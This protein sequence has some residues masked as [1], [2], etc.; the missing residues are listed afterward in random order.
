MGRGNEEL[1][2][3]G[4]LTHDSLRTIRPLGSPT[5]IKKEKEKKEKK[6][7]QG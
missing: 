1:E 6:K 2:P 3:N 5:S 4:N 7:L